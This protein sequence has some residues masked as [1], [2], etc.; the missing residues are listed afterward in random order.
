MPHSPLATAVEIP[1][2]VV[3]GPEAIAGSTRLKGGLAQKMV[4]HT[5]STTVMVRLGRVRGNLMTSLLP[6]SQKLRERAVHIVS[7]LAGCSEER[8]RTALEGAG[9]SIEAALERLAR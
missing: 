3:V 7:E 9:G 6:V 1:I 2:V 5:L 8:A 4:L